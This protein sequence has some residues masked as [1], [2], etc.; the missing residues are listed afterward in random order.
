ML[1]IKDIALSSYFA[2]NCHQEWILD[3][4]NVFSESIELI[5]WVFLSVC[6]YGKS[7]F[8]FFSQTGSRSVA[9]ASVK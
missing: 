5:I 4:F 9:H 7:L 1:F 6:K 8:F 3:F 2:K